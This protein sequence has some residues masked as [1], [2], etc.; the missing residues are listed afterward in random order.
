MTITTIASQ[1][2]TNEQLYEQFQQ[3][4]GLDLADEPRLRGA[5]QA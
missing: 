1:L 3:A 4:M 2:L 5:L